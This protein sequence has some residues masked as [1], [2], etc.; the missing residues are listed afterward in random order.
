MI[1]TTEKYAIKLSIQEFN[2]WCTGTINFSKYSLP[3]LKGVF[4]NKLMKNLKGTPAIG[5]NYWDAK[6]Y[7]TE[8]IDTFEVKQNKLFKLKFKNIDSYGAQHTL[9]SETMKK[10]NEIVSELDLTSTF[11]VLPNFADKINQFKIK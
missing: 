2:E 9:M 7:R 10:F 8:L 4:F 3:E 5:P 6:K 11:D 1:D